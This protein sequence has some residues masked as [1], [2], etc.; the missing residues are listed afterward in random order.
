MDW[1]I[2]IALGVVALGG[3]FLI[4]NKVGERRRPKPDDEA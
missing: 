1:V 4:G 2:A 3:G